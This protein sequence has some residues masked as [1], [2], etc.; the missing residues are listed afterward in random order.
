ML[1]KE[2]DHQNFVS[3]YLRGQKK[4]KK[5]LI[6]VG[7]LVLTTDWSYAVVYWR[8]GTQMIRSHA[9]TLLIRH[10]GDRYSRVIIWMGTWRTLH[11]QRILHRPNTICVH[12]SVSPGVPRPWA[13]WAGAE[14]SA[15]WSTANPTTLGHIPSLEIVQKLLQENCKS[16]FIKSIEMQRTLYS[17]VYPLITF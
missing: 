11:P 15:D 16:V 9:I 1:K 12:G 17:N 3:I 8:S 7:W 5:S 13:L 2:L 14:C 4:K 10:R 6:K